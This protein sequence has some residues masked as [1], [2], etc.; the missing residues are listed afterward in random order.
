MSGTKTKAQTVKLTHLDEYESVKATA[1]HQAKD[2]LIHGLVKAGLFGAAQGFSGVDTLVA[3]NEL[4]GGWCTVQRT[5]PDIQALLAEMT[6]HPSIL[7][8]EVLTKQ[9][10]LLI[11][12]VAK[13]LSNETYDVPADALLHYQDR[14][15]ASGVYVLF[16][17][18]Q[19]DQA[20]PGWRERAAQMR[21][22]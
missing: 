2:D 6:A 9:P 4:L 20:M 11:H 8:A 7:Y 5:D 1:S 17:P 3:Q 10:E 14:T 21:E 22:K 18:A 13:E 16:D 19:A 12:V 15:G